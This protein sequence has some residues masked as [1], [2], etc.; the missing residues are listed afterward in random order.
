MRQIKIHKILWDK[1]LAVIKIGNTSA[2]IYFKIVERMT[3]TAPDGAVHDYTFIGEGTDRP[4]TRI[5][6]TTRLSYSIE[7]KNNTAH[8]SQAEIEKLREMMT[9]Y[10]YDFNTSVN[11]R[12]KYPPYYHQDQEEINK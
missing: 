12:S 2:S 3:T 9:P 4:Q 7:I 8:M 11:N 5:P 1:D 10:L 6:R